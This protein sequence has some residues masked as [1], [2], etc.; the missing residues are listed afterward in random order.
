MPRLPSAGMLRRTLRNLRLSGAMLGDIFRGRYRRFPL[1]TTIALCLALF[2]VTNPLDLMPD[3]LFIIGYVD[4]LT[5]VFLCMVL[6]EKDLAHY[7]RWIEIK[8]NN[9]D[10]EVNYD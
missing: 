1:W 6:L 5:V 8:E 10:G 2:Y 3:G 9:R 4:D 7:L